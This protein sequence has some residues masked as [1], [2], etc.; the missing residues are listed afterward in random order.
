MVETLPRR[1]DMMGPYF[2]A[3]RL[4]LRWGRFPNMWRFPTMGSDLG[5]GGNFPTGGRS[6]MN[7]NKTPRRRRRRRAIVRGDIRGCGKG[8]FGI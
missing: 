4:R 3:R 2:M 7:E 1:I 8:L 6:W 5:P